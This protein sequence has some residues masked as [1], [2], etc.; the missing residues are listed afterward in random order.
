M[1][2]R[3]LKIMLLLVIVINT[4]SFS[5][6][7]ANEMSVTLNGQILSFDVPPQMIDNRT[8]VPL[9]NIFEAMGATVDWNDNTKTVTAT[10]GSEV[11]IATIDDKNVSINGVN[12]LL[13]VPPMVID[14]RTLVPVR[15]VAESFGA[16]VE[17][18]NTSKTVIITTDG[19]N[20]SVDTTST[21][22][23]SITFVSDPSGYFIKNFL[24]GI[25]V[26]W[27][28][29]NTSG[30]VINYYT[31][32]YSFFNAVGDPAYDEITDLS[33]RKINVVGPV[34][35]GGYI[36]DSGIAGYVPVCHSIR[37]DSI[38]LEYA[39]GSTESIVCGQYIYEVDE[40]DYS[41]K[42]MILDKIME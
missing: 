8:M 13:D 30:K 34:Q 31:I 20:S 35:P 6:I 3:I 5:T 21:H 4:N 29:T 27:G 40:D 17:W 42:L 15:F 33:T 37:V 11:V 38:D 22:S 36:C 19:T 10:K 9:R 2:K 18:D 24:D 32:N 25:E 26:V 12:K 14:G 41:T 16:N 23:P 28:A 1:S 39:D 7:A